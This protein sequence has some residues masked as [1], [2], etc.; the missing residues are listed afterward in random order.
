LK[1]VTSVACTFDHVT[2]IL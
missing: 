2:C 1:K